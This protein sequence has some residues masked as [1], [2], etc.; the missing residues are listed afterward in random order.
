MDLLDKLRSEIERYRSKRFVKA[1][2]A[3]CA[4]VAFADGGLSGGERGRLDAIVRH[5]NRFPEIDARKAEQYLREY[6]AALGADWATASVVLE[7]KIVGECTSWKKARTVLRL[8][9]NVVGAPGGEI[10]KT[11]REFER[12]CA[13]VRVAPDVARRPLDALST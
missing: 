10:S 12:L 13:L 5:L 11:A 8:A 3:A 6:I 7:G 1:A 2:V 9:H 4:L